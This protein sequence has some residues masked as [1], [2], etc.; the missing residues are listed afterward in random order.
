[1]GWSG[2]CVCVRACARACVRVRLK[3]GWMGVGGVGFLTSSRVAETAPPHRLTCAPLDRERAA[4]ENIAGGIRGEL[5]IDCLAEM[6]SE[7]VNES[8]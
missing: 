1:M 8:L 6:R 5:S 3:G 7:I 2:A 4:R